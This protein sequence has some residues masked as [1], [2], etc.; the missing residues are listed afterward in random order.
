MGPRAQQGDNVK[1][2]EI[3]VHRS[4]FLEAPCFLCASAPP[5]A[6]S[7]ASAKGGP[8]PPP[9]KQFAR[10]DYCAVGYRVCRKSSAWPCQLYR[11]QHFARE[12]GEAEGVDVDD[13]G[14]K[15]D[16]GSKAGSDRD[17]RRNLFELSVLVLHRHLQDLHL[18]AILVSRLQVAGYRVSRGRSPTLASPTPT[19]QRSDGRSEFPYGRRELDLSDGFSICGPSLL[20]GFSQEVDGELA[21][22]DAPCH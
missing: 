17:Q 8:S 22:D 14:R 18:P 20:I 2:Q 12:G 16:G 5:P 4:V 7:S 10:S 1:G 15:Q 19:L 6:E 11:V 13:D 21:P 9:I 3:G